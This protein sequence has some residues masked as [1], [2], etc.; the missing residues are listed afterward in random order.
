MLQ[1]SINKLKELDA[2]YK[3]IERQKEQRLQRDYSSK[4]TDL[5][6]EKRT[7]QLR[8]NQFE[9]LCKEQTLQLDHRARQ[10]HQDQQHNHRLQQHNQESKASLSRL[11]HDLRA[12]Q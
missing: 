8:L 5:H 6:Q 1:E 10:Q 3:H 7:L 12:L 11:D 4:L 2:D 9:S